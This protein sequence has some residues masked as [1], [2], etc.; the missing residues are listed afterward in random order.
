M[1]R[2]EQPIVAKKEKKGEKRAHALAELVAAWVAQEERQTGSWVVGV[3]GERG[4]GKTSLLL[5]LLDV[6]QKKDAPKLVLPSDGDSD[7]KKADVK[8]L[9]KPAALRDHDDLI[10]GLLRH[11]EDRYPHRRETKE[12]NEAREIEVRRKHTERFL[13]Y[14][15]DVAAS[16]ADLQQRAVKI[17]HDAAASTVNLKE[18]F[19]EIVSHLRKQGETTLVL[20]IDDLDLRPKRAL[21]LLE[22]FHIFLDQD[23]VIIVLAADKSLLLDGIALGLDQRLKLEERRNLAGALLAKYVPYEWHL[24]VLTKGECFDLLWPEQPAGNDESSLKRWWPSDEE[25]GEVPYD[26]QSSY[27]G[28]RELANDLIGPLLP[29]TYRGFHRYNNRLGLAWDELE[30]SLKERPETIGVKASFGELALEGQMLRAFLSGVLAFDERWPDHKL[31][32]Q[33][34]SAPGNFSLAFEALVDDKDPEGRGGDGRNANVRGRDGRNV[35]ARDGGNPKALRYLLRHLPSASPEAREAELALRNVG[36]LWKTLRRH[37]QSPPPP[38]RFLSVSLNSDAKESAEPYWRRDALEMVDEW[39]IDLRT[40]VDDPNHVTGEELKAARKEAEKKLRE[41]GVD[42]SPVG[43]GVFLRAN[44]PFAAW[45]GWVLRKQQ[46]ISVLNQR[47]NDFKLFF[48]PGK[49]LVAPSGLVTSVL[50]E[51]RRS[52]GGPADVA[53]L[54]VDLLGKSK[55]EQLDAF[56]DEQGAPVNY[57]VGVHLCARLAR[58]LSPSDA[59]P[60]LLHCVKTLSDLQRQGVTDVHLGLAVPDTM[61]FLLGQQLHARVN[62]IHLYEYRRTPGVYEYMFD[63]EEP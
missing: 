32:H 5:T 16:G 39:H 44:L 47:G 61:A 40:W 9:L 34:H 24:P 10:F 19:N 52:K 53:V 2:H 41:K 50:N 3:Y 54:L 43:V 4:A 51:E 15:Q 20:F 56:R 14:E 57:G 36:H 7:T 13:D 27:D 46:K 59:K 42:S 37:G 28:G 30:V 18:Q 63:L 22:I 33:V 48:G 29:T 21:E 62:R 60:F 17:F 1:T 25:A 23:G 45:L 11:L 49:E 55:A 38:V 8:N 35:K 26:N 31:W 12:F 58:D 6:L